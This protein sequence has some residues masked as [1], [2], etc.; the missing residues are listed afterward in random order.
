VPQINRDGVAIHF[1]ARGA[2]PVVLFT[3]GY[4]AS[5]RMWA[6]QLEALSSRFRVVAW[7]LRG[8]GASDSPEDPDAYS[9]ALAIADMEAVL[10]AAGAGAAPAVIAGH[11]L[12]GYLSLAFQQA[13]PA[14]TRA[15]MLFSTGP[16]Y[17]RDD[18]RAGWNAYAEKQARRYEERGLAAVPD[19]EMTAG[20]G[21]RS[22]RGLALAARGILAQRDAHVID[23][24][25]A[26]DVPTLIL[27][28][29]RDERYFAGTDYMAAKIPGARKILIEQAGH[30]VNLEQPEAFDAA[31]LDFLEALPTS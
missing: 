18:A 13:H 17:R 15:L 14:R 3:H 9:E 1:E 21:H 4:C 10:D 19:G 2:G 29:A 11:S 31:L 6:P 7:D 22:A 23:G 8:H 28:G 30:A 5:G 20:A 26:V 16:G 25:D 12:G 27:I 24:L